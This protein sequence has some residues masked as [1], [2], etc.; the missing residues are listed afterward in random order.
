MAP[1]LSEEA[2][3]FYGASGGFTSIRKLCKPG[4]KITIKLLDMNKDI[5]SKYKIKDKDYSYLVSLEKDGSRLRMNVNSKDLIRQLVD[6]LYP[7]GPTKPISPCWATLTRRVERKSF[8]SE[9][10]IT[11]GEALN[12]Q[13]QL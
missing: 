10:S 13:I 12:D 3:E 6:A 7:D 11:R 4:E 8:E 5:N 1:I 2:Q 9:A